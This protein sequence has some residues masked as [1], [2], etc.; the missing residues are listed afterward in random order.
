[1][2]PKSSERRGQL[3]DFAFLVFDMLAGDRVEFLDFHFFR[4]RSSIL[5]GYIE[6]PG[7]CRGIQSNLDRCRFSHVTS[8]GS[9]QMAGQTFEGRT[10]IVALGVV[11]FPVLRMAELRRS[12][13]DAQS[14]L[15]R[16]VCKPDS[17][18]RPSLL[19][20]HSS[21]RRVAATAQAAYPDQ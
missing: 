4:H 6:M 21:S 7:P 20:D 15:A 17:V 8:S 2:Q 3:L 18:Q 14:V 5:F 9:R 13:G 1:M 11:N 12:K 16:T 10:Y 19:D